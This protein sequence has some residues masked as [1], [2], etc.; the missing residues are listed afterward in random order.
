[1]KCAK[2]QSARLAVLELTGDVAT[3]RQQLADAEEELAIAHEFIQASDQR[4][5][6]I[7]ATR[8]PSP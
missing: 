7:D 3:L 2:C 4:Q 6:F 8:R 5:R 1:M